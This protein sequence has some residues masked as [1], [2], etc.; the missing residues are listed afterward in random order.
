[1]IPGCF[2]FPLTMAKH[3]KYVSPIFKERALLYKSPAYKQIAFSHFE[4]VVAFPAPA[5][6]VFNMSFPPTL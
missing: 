4:Y 3:T 2:F 5:S 6:C 1:M